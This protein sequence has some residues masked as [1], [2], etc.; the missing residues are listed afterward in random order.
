[1]ASSSASFFKESSISV[2]CVE[3]ILLYT[4]A[5]VGEKLETHRL[6][7]Q[8]KLCFRALRRTSKNILVPQHRKDKVTHICTDFRCGNSPLLCVQCL[9]DSTSRTLHGNHEEF[10]LPI[11]EA[12]PELAVIIDSSKSEMSKLFMATAGRKDS[13]Q[14]LKKMEL[15]D[16]MHQQMD[17]H[18]KSLKQ[19]VDR[20][21]D[22]L[23]TEFLWRWHQAKQSAVASI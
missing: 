22:S 2:S 19:Q 21:F 18:I 15:G 12:I 8:F 10:L 9:S 1:V 11:H 5:N 13:E 4:T 20:E 17:G 7:L 6:P 16:R 14:L 23:Q 3:V